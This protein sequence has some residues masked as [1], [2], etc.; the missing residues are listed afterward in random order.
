MSTT[1]NIYRDSY[2]IP[3]IEA[4]SYA[5]A[6]Y[7]LGYAMAHDCAARMVQL[8][9]S[10]IGRSAEVVGD[11]ALEMDYLVRA[12]DL[13][14]AARAEA[15]ALD[16][17]LS[18]IVDAFCEGA[19]RAID[20][21][22]GRLPAWVRPISRVDILALVH[23]SNIAF[24]LL[25]LTKQLTP[26][27]GSNQFA[28]APRHTANG[29]AIVSLD[30]HLDWDKAI[31]WYEFACY[32]PENNPGLTNLR[33]VAVCGTPLP[34]M[35]H[36]DRVAWSM[37]NNNPMLHGLFSLKTNPTDPTQ[38]SYHGEWRRFDDSVI[39]LRYIDERG[40]T[41]TERRPVRRTEWGP[42][43]PVGSTSCALHMPFVDARRTLGQ[44]LAMMSADNVDDF[45]ERLRPLGLSMWNFVFADIEGALGYQYNAR[46]HRR[47]PSFDWSTPVPGDDPRTRW[48]EPI[49]LDELPNLMNPA[50]GVLINA[51]SS[52]WLTSP[53][54]EMPEAA[55]PAYVTSHPVTFRHLRLA[56][57]LDNPRGVTPEHAMRVA[58]DTMTPA[59]LAVRDRLIEAASGISE[60]AAAFDVLRDWDGRADLDSRGAAL[61]HYWLTIFGAQD[62][63]LKL[64]DGE[65]WTPSETEAA[66]SALSEASGMMK[67][68]HGRVDVPWGEMHVSRRNGLEAPV[69]GFYHAV[70]PNNGPLIG[71]KVVCDFGSSFR[72]IVE[73]DPAGVR[74]WSA[75]P[76]G[77][78]LSP[79]S[80]HFTDQME[81]FGRGEYKDTHFGLER[82][83]AAA[84][85][86]VEIT[87]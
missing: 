70:A 80:P 15:P 7:G 42:V 68:V 79:A 29:H 21:Q 5:D 57:L 40:I 55:W 82:T 39:E 10:A 8:Y 36:N 65:V 52:P 30:P 16:A 64:V 38:Y 27:S 22:Q 54:G 20:E 83:K 23:L 28:L 11:I 25:E 48:G 71:G 44:A 2:G 62:L 45:R 49:P 59:G 87:R 69:T 37:T 50:A 67:L 53:S 18:S 85:A 13:E 78:A 60:L 47:D 51:N 72:M 19:N 26:G 33:G 86:V 56:E 61:Y 41:Q 76:Y 12:L 35:G 1:I 75:K 24:P 3:S 81:M 34:I 74:S 4:R 32:S 43:I 77:N 63:A 73:L 9:L 17:E 84:K 31:S 14:S 66:L 46:V 58:T 6:A